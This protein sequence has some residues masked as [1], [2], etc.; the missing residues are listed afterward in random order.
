MDLKSLAFPFFQSLVRGSRSVRFD[1]PARVAPVSKLF[2]FER[3][4]PIDRHYIERF[5]SSHGQHI[6]GRALEVASS[7]YIRRFHR[8]ATAFEVLHV[9][10]AVPGTTIVGDLA[11]WQ[12]LPEA[13]VDA[14]VCTHTFNFIYDVQAAVRGAHR[15]LAPGGTLI[16]TLAGLAQI[17]R[18]DMDRWGDFWRFTS[19]SAAR[20]FGAEFARVEV[21][22][23]GNVLAAKAL[24]DGLA[25]EDLPSPGLL[26]AVDPD[27]QVVIGV[28]AHK[29]G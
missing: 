1:D 7:D 17:S 18:Y 4:R 10:A 29:A 9:D 22:T 28:V 5:V 13:R 15:L 20:L 23:Y 25:V 2:G 14:F 27:Y 19:G 6:R 26:D 3:G 8:G 24:L 11:D 21:T 16:A 12:S